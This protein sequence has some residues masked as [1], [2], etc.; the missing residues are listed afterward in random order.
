MKC[1]YCEWR[2]EMPVSICRMYKEKDG[3][4]TEIYPHQWTTYYLTST[5]SIPLFHGWPNNQFLQIG[6][7]NCNAGCAYCINARVAIEPEKK[8]FRYHLTP[9]QVVKSALK[10]NCSGIHFGVNE[11]T[12]NLP[13]ALAVAREAK[14]HGLVVGCSSNGYFTTEAAAMM[15]EYFDFFNLSLKS[16]SDDFYR[17]HLLLESA[18]PVRRNIEY[19]ASRTHLEITTPVVQ[20][21]NDHEI[22]AI[23]AYL[24]AIDPQMPWHIFR[25][26]P[27]YKM[28]DRLLPDIQAIS[29]RV[30]ECRNILHNTYFSNYI[31]SQLINTAC[32][33]CGKLLIERISAQSC[34]AILSGYNMKENIC[35][36]CRTE[37]KMIGSFCDTTYP[38]DARRDSLC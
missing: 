35:P 18:A 21:V 33:C 1:N 15:L 13:S 29:D 37:I 30:R 26:L 6:A 24:A 20:T 7:F 17:E 11:V 2:C 5:E 3:K 23:A 27:E 9:E 22:P 28:E 8:T 38:A 14:K 25:L 19:L 10:A 34:G 16:L 31:G 4:F 12:V 32:P 36:D